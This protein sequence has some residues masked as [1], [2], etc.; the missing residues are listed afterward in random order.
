M[1]KCVPRRAGYAVMRLFVIVVSHN[2]LLFT[3]DR[4]ELNYVRSAV[5]HKIKT[6]ALKVEIMFFNLLKANSMHQRKW[7]V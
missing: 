6:F 4:L 7:F 1:F 5:G 3:I 2:T